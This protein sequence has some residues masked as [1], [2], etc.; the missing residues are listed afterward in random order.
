[1][2]PAELRAIEYAAF[3]LSWRAGHF[4]AYFQEA[5]VA[6]VL[7]HYKEINQRALVSLARSGHAAAHTSLCAMANFLTGIDDP[8]PLWLQDYV[9]FAA[10]VGEGR[11]ERGRDAQENFLR[12]AAIGQAVA[13]VTDAFD[14]RPTRNA[15]TSAECGCS[16]VAEA[17]ARHFNVHMTEAN[18]VSIWRRTVEREIS[19]CRD[20]DERDLL[21]LDPAF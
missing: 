8:L 9:L 15:A 2:A 7:C 21:P 14:L 13:M 6:L 12:D 4:R 16:I 19:R 11:R 1:M 20:L 10:Q 18:V 17:L 5:E 3:A